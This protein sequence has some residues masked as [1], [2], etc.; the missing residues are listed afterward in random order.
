MF[1]KDCVGELVGR[2]LQCVWRL[3]LVHLSLRVLGQQAGGFWVW[4]GGHWA[5][6]RGRM[7]DVP[8]LERVGATVGVHPAFW[9]AHG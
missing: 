9:F 8:G 4:S 7:V 5:A 2:T 6:L 3:H 1:R